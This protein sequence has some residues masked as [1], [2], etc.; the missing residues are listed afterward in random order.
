MSIQVTDFKWKKGKNDLEYIELLE[1]S[2]EH[3]RAIISKAVN[4]IRDLS[5]E[6]KEIREKS[7]N[8][9][10]NWLYENH[11]KDFTDYIE[12]YFDEI[13]EQLKGV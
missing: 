8:E 12:R 6:N 3:Q 5:T 4:K 11:K 7:I 9:F 13:A 2:L 10:A 1:K